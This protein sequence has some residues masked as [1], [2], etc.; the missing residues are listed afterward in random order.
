MVQRLRSQS[1]FTLIE[2]VIIIVVLG[3]LAA[4][5]IPKY[6][7]ITVEAKAAACKGALGS[8]RSGVSIYYASQIVKRGT[9]TWPPID[10]LRRVGTVILQSLPANPYQV[11]TQAPDSV[12]T[13]VTK[14]VVV[15]TRGGW[16]YNPTT[17]EVWANTS[18]A[19]ENSW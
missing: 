6:Q 10:S 19:G 11:S 8:L 13:G 9:A 12:V 4:V 16:A 2:L 3:I 14:G 18:T 15:G 1:G 17:G 7:D 5:A